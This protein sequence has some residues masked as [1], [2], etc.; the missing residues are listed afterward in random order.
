MVM[1][2]KVFIL[3]LATI[4]FLSNAKTVTCS[5]GFRQ[6]E[7]TYYLE[8][9]SPCAN[10]KIPRLGVCAYQSDYVG[11]TALVYSDN[12]GTQG[13]LIG[14]YE[15][16]YTGYGRKESNGKGTIQN[17]NTIDIFMDSSEH[18]KE[19]IKEHGNKVFIKLVDAKG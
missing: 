19:F 3:T 1:R 8:T 15:I 17:G 13:E 18:G 5:D 9:G 12:D 11:M 16:Y 14:I 2:N 10:G 6:V 4:L 7:M